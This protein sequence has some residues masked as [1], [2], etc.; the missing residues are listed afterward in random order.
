M[1][2]KESEAQMVDVA[3]CFELFEIF[4]D[5]MKGARDRLGRRVSEET[6]STVWLELCKGNVSQPRRG[7]RPV[8]NS[9]PTNVRELTIVKS[10]KRKVRW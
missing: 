9:R 5:A 4:S 6:Q 2:F 8:R 10:C 1:F 7:C 3:N